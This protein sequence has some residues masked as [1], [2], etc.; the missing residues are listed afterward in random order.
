MFGFLYHFQRKTYFV[1]AGFLLWTGWGELNCAKAQELAPAPSTPESLVE[2]ALARNP[3]IRLY[4]SKIDAARGELKSAAAWKNPSLQLQGGHRQVEPDAGSM[5]LGTVVAGSLCQ[6]FEFPGKASLRKAMARGDIELAE[7]GLAQFRLALAGRVQQLCLETV[8]SGQRADLAVTIRDQ[9]EELIHL[10]KQRKLGGARP[11]LEMRVIEAGQIELDDMALHASLESDEAELELRSLLGRPPSHEPLGISLPSHRSGTVPDALPPVLEQVHSGNI[12]LRIAE[13]KIDQ[14][15]QSTSAARL[16]ALPDFSFGPFFSRE[17]SSEGQEWAVGGMFSTDLPL[18]NRNEGEVLKR[19]ALIEQAQ[20]RY[21][22]ARLEAER[23][24]T[25]HWRTLQRL[26]GHFDHLTPEMI[27]KLKDSAELADRQYRQGVIE[28]GLYLESQKALLN[29]L[30][31]YHETLIH[32]QN[33]LLD[34]HLLTGG[35]LLENN[36]NTEKETS[37]ENHTHP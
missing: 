2:E 31:H 16:D 4:Q 9:S 20:A 15:S 13:R 30:K 27:E 24:A 7:L 12:G 8:L 36:P 3:E 28:V 22:L 19:E 26:D 25:L 10:L 33:A 5:A 1:L 37:H 11:L 35:S 23:A 14:A 32:R 34:L 17:A 18:W 6:P 21:D 29:T